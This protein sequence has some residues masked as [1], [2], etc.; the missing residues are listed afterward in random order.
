MKVKDL[1]IEGTVL[2]EHPL[3]D[4]RTMRRIGVKQLTDEGSHFSVTWDSD[5]D[6]ETKNFATRA[7]AE[8]FYDSIS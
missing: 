4:T 6:V 7:R 5:R 1:I 3:Y 2:E 8:Q